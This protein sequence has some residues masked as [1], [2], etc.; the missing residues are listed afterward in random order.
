MDLKNKR[1]IV[2]GA[3]GVIGR[4]LT[5]RLESQGAQIRC[6]DLR[7]KPKNFA[8]EVEYFQGDLSSLNKLEFIAF[9]PDLIFH[10]SA[11]FDRT[12]EEL[13][14]WDLNWQNEILVNHQVID[15]ARECQ[16]LVKFIFAS[17][18]LIYDPALYL[19][20]D[21]SKP[22]ISLGETD[23]I[24]PRNLCGAAKLYGERELIY[25]NQFKSNYFFSNVFARIFRVYGRGSDDV[26]EK[27]VKSAMKRETFEVFLEQNRFD[28]I[29]A[30]D[31][32]E[33]LIRLAK[34]QPATGVIN[35][36]SGASS[37]VSQV[38][39]E[40]KKHYPGFRIR[41]TD[42][43]ELLEASGADINKLKKL[44]GWQPAVSLAQGI[45]ILIDYNKKQ[46]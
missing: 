27:L 46:S 15:A 22:V 13:D 10:L 35:L 21:P 8:A 37:S 12:E 14:F 36:G 26:V 29:F 16:G 7:P 9:K 28:Y 43:K 2:T 24:N 33:G 44:T 17:S 42:R 20:K 23:R 4:E 45:K 38:I 40:V 1:V 32:A 34:S 19:V 30:G 31:V 3:A 25:L 39:A 6:F 41:K 11:V 5:E 18:Y